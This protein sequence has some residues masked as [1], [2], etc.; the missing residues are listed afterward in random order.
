M[1]TW[2]TAEKG[3]GAWAIIEEHTA[4]YSPLQWTFQ[5]EYWQ[6]HKSI[7]FINWLLWTHTNRCG[8]Q[9]NYIFLISIDAQCSITKRD[10]LD[11]HPL[12][13]TKEC[14]CPYTLCF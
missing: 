9:T 7:Y 4:N 5:A 2:A 14:S 3:Q 1:S 6:G 12:R 11:P 8:E 13:K 10:E